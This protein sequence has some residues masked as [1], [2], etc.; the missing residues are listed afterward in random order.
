[1]E[2]R[3]GHMLSRRRLKCS[4]ALRSSSLGEHRSVHM[5]R[6]FCTELSG[7]KASFAAHDQNGFQC[8][9][10]TRLID[11]GPPLMSGLL[12]RAYRTIEGPQK[13]GLFYT[14]QQ[15]PTTPMK[16]HT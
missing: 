2:T 7:S 16:G 11:H 4:K 1:M 14:P 9:A 3:S 12:D 15:Y 13:A 6:C 8:W 10:L 5:D